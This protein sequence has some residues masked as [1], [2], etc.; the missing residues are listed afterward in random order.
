VLLYS[1]KELEELS[2][3]PDVKYPSIQVIRK[4]YQALANFLQ[5]PIASGEGI[6][7]DFNMQEF[8]SNFK[9]DPIQV[10]NALKAL[11][12]DGHL[13]FDEQVFIAAKAG[14]TCDKKDLEDFEAA[15]PELETLIKYLLRSYH[16]IF[17]NRVSIN[18]SQ[19]SRLI[20]LS[21]EE[22][23]SPLQ[24]LKAFNI[25]EYVPQK[26]TP[27]IYFTQNRAPA[28]HLIFNQEDYL[29]RK[30]EYSIRV[31]AMLSYVKLEKQCRGQYIGKYFGDANMKNCG[32][33]D[34]CL[35][36]KNTLL[37]EE[38]F[39]KIEQQ[40]YTHISSQKSNVNDLLFQLKT[41][42]K[43]KVWK[44]INYLQSERK[45]MLDESGSIQRT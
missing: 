15:H 45:I 37:T 33:C 34:N 1:D 36:Q 19:V 43:D 24:Q 35:R 23:H 38:E 10:I 4:I 28:E 16:G 27:Q 29:K 30:K 13:T 22:V 12:Q 2:K 31:D 40:I 21:V 3:L 11:E 41:I 8:V 7:Y 5:I 17:D 26:E 39:S 44:V 42:K 18:E 20:K 14:F 6:Y 9:L 25:L 32:L